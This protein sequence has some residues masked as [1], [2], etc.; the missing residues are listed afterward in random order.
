MTE[1]EDT[2]GEDG[3]GFADC[4]HFGH[5]VDV[6]GSATG[7]DRNAD[8][9]ADGGGE[10]EVV[11]FLRSVGI[12]AGEEDLPGS[13]LGDFNGPVDGLP[14]GR[15]TTSVGVDDPSAVPVAARVDRDD[16]ALGAESLGRGV[17][18]IRIIE[19]GGVHA[20]LVGSGQKHG[21]HILDLADAATDGEGHEAGVRGLLD[22]LA[23]GGSSLVGGGDVEE[24]EFVGPLGI[25]GAGTLDGIPGITDVLELGSLDDPAAIDVETGDDAFTEHQKR[26]KAEG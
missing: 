6:S 13:A 1:V 17:H 24:D 2:C 20:D 19:G 25:V 7:D 16:D 22:H 11:A 9:I 14:C 23:H 21:A 15:L 4:E 8:R 3:V 18:E 26:L 12:H 10:F 5:V